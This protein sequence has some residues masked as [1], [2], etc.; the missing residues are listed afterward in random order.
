MDLNMIK[1]KVF[2][3]WDQ[4]FDLI[5]FVGGTILGFYALYLLLRFA[6]KKNFFW[7]RVYERLSKI[8]AAILAIWSRIMAIVLFLITLVIVVTIIAKFILFFWSL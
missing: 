2:Q 1:F 3:F 6:A 8:S 7:Q 5:C 4:Y